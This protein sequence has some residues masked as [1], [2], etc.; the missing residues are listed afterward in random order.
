MSERAIVVSLVLLAALMHASWN[1]FTK[2]ST[3]PL[4]A[5]WMITVSAGIGVLALAPL[6]SFPR[7]EA[8][9]YIG[10]SLVLHLVYE[11]FLVSAY[12]LGDLSQV[13]PIARGLGPC[14]VALLA[15]TFAAE[16]LTGTQASGLVLCSLSLASL[17]FVTRRS[18]ALAARAVAAAM[19]TGLMIGSY[20]F[21]DAQGVRA[22]DSPFDFIVWS[23]FLDSLPITG[24]VLL[25]RR[26]RILAY[27]RSDG[28]R[29][30]LAG[31]LAVAAYGIVLW[32]MSTT[33]MASVAALRETSVVFA[34]W[35]GTRLFG[36]P[37]GL[38]RLLAACG[39][40]IGVL[41]L[42]I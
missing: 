3:D 24:V 34:A 2:R 29:G 9:P 8:W 41:L 1:A 32:A 13:Y 35:I 18:S 12:R 19:V 31:I 28:R 4:L 39:V 23:I 7:A 25:R 40:A 6:A 27:L 37:F 11:L 15:A 17:A 5:I 22:C 14:V 38:S 36:E 26:G 20:T 42:Q 16:R 33:P 10:A 21:V 30:A